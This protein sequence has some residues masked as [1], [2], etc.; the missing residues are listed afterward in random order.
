MKSIGLVLLS[1]QQALSRV[2]DVVANNVANASTTGFK[3]E[4]IEFDTLVSG[5]AS[6]KPINFVVDRATYRDANVGPIESTSN[7]L[8]LAIE[9]KGYFQVQT[10]SGVQYTRSGSFTLNSEGQMVTHS[11]QPVLDDGG[12]PIAFP[13]DVGAIN[14]SGDGY[15][16]AKVGTGTTLTE[17]GKIGVVTFDN[18]QLMQSQGNGLYSTT[19]AATPSTDSH[20]VQGAIEQSNVQP[21]SEMTTMIQIMRA[22]EQAT[23][24]ISQ[25][26]SRMNDAIS[27]LSKTTA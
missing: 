11:G 3:R 27:K 25:E 18:E 6:G 22:Y 16:T 2:M 15:I 9:G 13:E 10:A 17:L 5:A 1:D 4:G 12:Q 24:M 23:N 21:I 20:V 7:P 8:D 26:N 19:Q 14:V